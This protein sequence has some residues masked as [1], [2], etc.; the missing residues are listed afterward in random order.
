MWGRSGRGNSACAVI[1]SLK[2]SLCH[3]DNKPGGFCRARY[4]KQARQHL[5]RQMPLKVFVRH[6]MPFTLFNQARA[7]PTL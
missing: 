4:Q 7:C 1:A 3:T 6:N 5:N 2:V